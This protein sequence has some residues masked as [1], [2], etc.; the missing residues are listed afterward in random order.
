MALWGLAEV[1]RGFGEAGGLG[2]EEVV[3]RVEDFDGFNY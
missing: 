2:G 1:L 3:G